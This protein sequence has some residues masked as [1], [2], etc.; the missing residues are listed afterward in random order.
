VASNRKASM[1]AKPIPVSLTGS[2]KHLPP[3]QVVGRDHK[4]MA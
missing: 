2:A 3:K 1:R 4:P